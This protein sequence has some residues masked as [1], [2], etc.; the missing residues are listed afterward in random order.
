LADSVAPGHAPFSSGC[1]FVMGLGKHQLRARFELASFI[2]CRS[3]QG[4]S[5][6]WS[7]PTPGPRA[8][9]S[10]R[11]ILRWALANSSCVLNFSTM[12][13]RDQARGANE[14]L[15]GESPTRRNKSCQILSPLVQGFRSPRRLKIAI[16][17][18]LEAS[19]LQQCYALTCY[20]VITL[21]S[22]DLHIF[23]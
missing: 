19:P 18:L 7:S 9:F 4:N 3:I 11:V 8:H 13:R 16:S 20:T 6:F 14:F 1:D 17:H 10:S 21:L 22:K 2:C 5:K 15:H 12:T 23:I